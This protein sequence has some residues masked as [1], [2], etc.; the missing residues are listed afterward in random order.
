MNERRS[1]S[2]KYKNKCTGTESLKG[3]PFFPPTKQL[4]L[5]HKNQGNKWGAQDG[6][7]S[8]WPCEYK[9]LVSFLHPT[10]G[11]QTRAV[12]GNWQN[13]LLYFYRTVKSLLSWN[14]L[15]K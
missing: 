7:V 9:C 13:F 4:P 5:N 14:A 10:Q 2:I 12:C 1:I 3:H 15:Y 11:F 6:A 8:Q